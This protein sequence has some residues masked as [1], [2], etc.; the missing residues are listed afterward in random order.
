VCGNSCKGRKTGAQLASDARSGTAR[1]ESM[2]ENS[3]RSSALAIILR[4]QNGILS[5]DC[6]A[7]RAIEAVGVS[8][9]VLSLDWI[10]EKGAI[11]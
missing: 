8:M 4:A 2:F 1:F 11:I 3:G 7:E 6:G 5:P 10:C 9:Q